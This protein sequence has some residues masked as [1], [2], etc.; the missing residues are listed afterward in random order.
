MVTSVDAHR[1]QSQSRGQADGPAADH[2]RAALGT[3]DASAASAS[4]AACQLTA[5]GS[6]NAA[7]FSGM[8]SGTV[9]KIASRASRRI[10]Q[11]PLRAAASK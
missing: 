6:A 11:M 2:K 4:R 5:N 8:S 3:S 10:A 9:D 1:L 7:L